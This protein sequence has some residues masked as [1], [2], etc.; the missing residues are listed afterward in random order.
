MQC[1]RPQVRL[2]RGPRHAG[3][4]RQNFRFDRMTDDF[5]FGQVSIRS[6]PSAIGPVPLAW[7]FATTWLRHRLGQRDPTS[8]P[9]SHIRRRTT[10]KRLLTLA[11]T[12]MAGTLAITGAV[13]AADAD[14]ILAT[15]G[16]YGGPSHA[17]AG[18]FVYN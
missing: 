16:I 9:I 6:C 5:A 17:A 11:V 18:C 13:R 10:M 12:T 1:R 4:P 3:G 2:I 14:D 8:S 7:A 15:G